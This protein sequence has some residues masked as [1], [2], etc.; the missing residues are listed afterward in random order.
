MS[1][2]R[3]PKGIPSGGQFAATAHAEPG[4][5]L[6]PGPPAG[7][8]KRI[9]GVRA[10][11]LILGQIPNADVLLYSRHRAFGR[12]RL[13]QLLD[14]RGRVI[15]SGEDMDFPVSR[16][17]FPKEAERR[18]AV[19]AAMK[20]LGGPREQLPPGVE[21]TS[22]V[23]QSGRLHLPT[24]LEYGPEVP[25]MGDLT[26]QQ[27]SAQRM[28]AALSNWDETDDDPQTTMRDL[29]TDL[30]HHA[31][32][33]NLDLGKALDGSYKVFLEEHNDPAFKEG[34]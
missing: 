27:A 31:A 28:E 32:A 34:F 5:Q 7:E 21:K 8:E 18:D 24:I 22:A 10:A 25:E 1:E 15:Y 16:A 19:R 33:N 11:T 20:L 3:Q 9:A 13:Y 17:R 23:L 2:A 14:S 12:A 6:H 29:L 30:R 4:V 26:P